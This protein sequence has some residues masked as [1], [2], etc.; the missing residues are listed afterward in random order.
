MKSGRHD[1]RPLTGVRGVAALFVMLYHLSTML[2]AEQK[3]APVGLFT[4]GYLAVDLFFVLSGFVLCYNY[5]GNFAGGISARD[6]FSLQ[7]KRVARIFPLYLVLLIVYALKQF[8]NF[9]ETAQPALHPSDWIL[10]VLALH[11]WGF[12]A[13]RIIGASWSISTELFAYLMLP[14]MLFGFTRLPFLLPLAGV[15]GGASL[16]AVIVYGQGVRGP[17]DVVASGSLLPLL[18][19]LAEFTLGVLACFAF[20]NARMGRYARLPLLPFLMGAALLLAALGLDWWLAA[21]LFP[22]AVFCMAAENKFAMAL[23]AN[24]PVHYLGTISY[25]IYLAHPLFVGIAVRA[26]RMIHG[27]AAFLPV[28]YTVFVVLTISAAAILYHVIEVPGSRFVRGLSSRSD[29]ADKVPATA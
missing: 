20:R 26:G 24:K 17:L 23:F 3:I 13:V 21:V 28:T 27:T 11:G 5:E 1:L 8:Y 15:A 22:L 18:R 10:N 9:S 4:R 14:L 16:L 19:C 7:L 29:A 2:T 6:Y 12:H 25:S